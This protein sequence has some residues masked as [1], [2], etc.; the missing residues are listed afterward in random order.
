MSG[1]DEFGFTRWGAAIV[2][3]AEPIDARMPNKEAPR[4]RSLARNGGVTLSFDGR[5][6][7]A[8]V[9][10][11]GQASIAHLEFAA[12]PTATA[13]AIRTHLDS[14]SEPDDAVFEAVRASGAAPAP[15]LE[16]ADCSC[17]AR[18]DRCVHILAALY[19]LA[20][21]VDHHP[22]AALELQ[23]YGTGDG[24][25]APGTDTGPAPRWI[26]ITRLDVRD[27]FVPRSGN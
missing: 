1:T 26:P 8:H 11:A 7:T 22:V 2:R 3:I 4:A 6:V 23:A 15:V 21:H 19:T 5:Q 14:R 10:R 25:E 17:K 12:M 16:A 27:Y 13:A 9:H 18:N 24:S 20:A